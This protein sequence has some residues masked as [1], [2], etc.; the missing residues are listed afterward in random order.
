MPMSASTVETPSVDQKS[1][2]ILLR[3]ELPLSQYAV[4]MGITGQISMTSRKLG[5]RSGTRK[6]QNF[7]TLDSHRTAV[8]TSE[9]IHSI[10]TIYVANI[11]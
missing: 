8:K 7:Y 1:H 5:K 6:V 4:W 9:I 11:L 10:L 3:H 2:I